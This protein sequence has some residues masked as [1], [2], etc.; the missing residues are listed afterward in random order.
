M[1]LLILFGN[2]NKHR[3]SSICAKPFE[4][5][6]LQVSSAVNFTKASLPVSHCLANVLSD[7]LLLTQHHLSCNLL[8]AQIMTSWQAGTL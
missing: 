7:P 5:V 4:W 8:R 2:K 1:N 3:S 6:N